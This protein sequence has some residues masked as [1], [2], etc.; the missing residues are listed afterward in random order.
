MLGLSIECSKPT[1]IK[2]GTGLPTGNSRMKRIA[3]ILASSLLPPILWISC[4]HAQ[5]VPAAAA[6]SMAQ[7]ERAAVRLKQ[8]MSAEE[9]QELIG[10]PRRTA[11]K[12]VG[13]ASSA[14]SPGT[15]QWTYSWTDSQANLR[16]DFLAKNPD[17]HWY[18]NNWE[19]TNY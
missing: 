3:L 16:I 13:G 10:Q 17:H 5:G 8:G 2:H 1:R 9:V 12:T 7:T 4:A 6:T 18:V 11:L 15:L 14:T 19:W